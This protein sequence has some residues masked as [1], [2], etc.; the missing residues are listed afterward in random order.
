MHFCSFCSRHLPIRP[1]TFAMPV[2]HVC[3][4]IVGKHVH[5]YANDVRLASRRVQEP[6]TRTEDFLEQAA[7]L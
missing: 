3:R 5:V 6:A 2:S 1:G 7:S 4:S